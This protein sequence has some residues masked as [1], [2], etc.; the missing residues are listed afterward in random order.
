MGYLFY[1]LLHKIVDN[2]R[3]NTKTLLHSKEYNIFQHSPSIMD[4]RKP[5]TNG[6]SSHY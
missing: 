3:H 4:E 5:H 6:K 2:F 1:T